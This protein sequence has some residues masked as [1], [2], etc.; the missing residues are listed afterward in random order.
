MGTSRKSRKR[1]RIS[2]ATVIFIF[3]PKNYVNA[4]PVL[5][6]YFDIKNYMGKHT[7]RLWLT[8]VIGTGISITNSCGHKM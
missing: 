7:G 6:I 2:T 8:M 4:T 5:P 1:A 3:S